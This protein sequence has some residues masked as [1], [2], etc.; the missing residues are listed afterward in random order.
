MSIDAG[1]ILVGGTTST[2]GGTSTGFIPKEDGN[3]KKVI[4]DD[5]SD[6]LAST[7][8]TFTARDPQVNASAPNGYTQQRSSM[9]A[10]VPL[11]LDNGGHTT[12]TISITLSYDV[13]TSDTEKEALTE[14]GAQLFR[15]AAFADFWRKQSMA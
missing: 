12:N 2:T 5:G 6:Y 3:P 15:S 13:E 14:L 9:K 11:S 7:T 1:T 4:L 10:V 8:I